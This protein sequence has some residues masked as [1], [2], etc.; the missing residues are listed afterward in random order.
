MR[1]LQTI[2]FLCKH[3]TVLPILQIQII[4]YVRLSSFGVNVASRLGREAY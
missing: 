2:H 1:E 3:I 4:D